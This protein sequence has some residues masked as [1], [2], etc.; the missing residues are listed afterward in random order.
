MPDALWATLTQPSTH[1][2]LEWAIGVVSSKRRSAYARPPAEDTRDLAARFR[3]GNKRPFRLKMAMKRLGSLGD[4]RGRNGGT[5][6]G[7]RDVAL[8]QGQIDGSFGSN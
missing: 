8:D 6:S 5:E 2:T 7:S 3:R 1:R 4:L